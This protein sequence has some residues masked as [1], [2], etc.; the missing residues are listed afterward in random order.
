LMW[1]GREIWTVGWLGIQG[2]WFC[3]GVLFFI[4]IIVGFFYLLFNMNGTG[5]MPAIPVRIVD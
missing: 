3:L 2:I 5:S 1:W 4:G